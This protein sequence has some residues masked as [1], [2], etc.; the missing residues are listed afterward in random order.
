M[1]SLDNSRKYLNKNNIKSIESF[2]NIEERG[3]LPNSFKRTSVTMI[4][5]TERVLKRKLLTIIPH[6][7]RCKIL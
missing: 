3:T 6:E 1:I 5:K 2:Q 4:L 7:Y